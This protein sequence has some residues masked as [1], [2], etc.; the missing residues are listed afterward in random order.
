MHT[1]LPLRSFIQAHPT[2]LVG[3][4]V[5]VGRR[6]D[7]RSVSR[8]ELAPARSC[9]VSV[10]RL[11]LELLMQNCLVI[12]RVLLMQPPLSLTEG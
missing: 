10:L 4:G 6:Q 1:Y 8:H 2:R 11:A 7:R 3:V 12:S 9:S 5:G